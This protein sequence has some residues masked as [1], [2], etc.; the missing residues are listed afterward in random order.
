[1]HLAHVVTHADTMSVTVLEAFTSPAVTLTLPV[2]TLTSTSD[3]LTSAA[4]ALTKSAAG[5]LFQSDALINPTL[6]AID[7][8][9]NNN[10]NNN[11]RIRIIII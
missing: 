5:T 10:N 1:M 2:D 7:V 9:Y 6:A 4:D 8:L 11:I 3:A